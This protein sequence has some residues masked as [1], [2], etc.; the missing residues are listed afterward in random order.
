MC[1]TVCVHMC[2][3]VVCVRGTDGG[4]ASNEMF[5][6]LSDDRCVWN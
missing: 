3:C 1:V 6:V 5:Q 4:M 2:A